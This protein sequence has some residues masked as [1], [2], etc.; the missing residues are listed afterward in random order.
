MSLIDWL[1]RTAPDPIESLIEA[2][3]AQ[4]IPGMERIDW[5]KTN[6]A[7]QKRWTDVARAQGKG[8]AT[9]REFPKAMEQ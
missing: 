2:N 7:G 4:P 6:Q 3:K 9:V 1:F 8:K 5:T